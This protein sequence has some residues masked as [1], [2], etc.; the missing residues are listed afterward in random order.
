M[1]APA[2]P[3]VDVPL[4]L[5]WAV[6]PSGEPNWQC[7][8]PLSG[9]NWLAYQT[10]QDSLSPAE[11]LAQLRA[12]HGQFLVRGVNP[13]LWAHWKQAGLHSVFSGLEAQLPPYPELWGKSS[14]RALVR[15]GL[16]HGEVVALDPQAV[17]SGYID[18]RNHTDLG[19]RPLLRGMFRNALQDAQRLFVFQ[20]DADKW[21]G[22]ITLTQNTPTY[23]HVELMQRRDDAEP[24]FMWR[25]KPTDPGGPR[26]HGSIIDEGSRSPAHRIAH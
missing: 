14:L 21:L 6:A 23:W 26:H 19:H 1:S 8:L 16:R 4:P 20:T 2:Q 24:P 15:R 17:H 22:F 11:R 5:S 3:Q 10:L 18:F 12:T 25:H 13:Q 7:R 9:V